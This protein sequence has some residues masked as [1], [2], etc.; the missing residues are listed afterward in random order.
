MP[1]VSM[2]NPPPG[3]SRKATRAPS[4]E[5]VTSRTAAATT[6]RVLSIGPFRI[7]GSDLFVR[8]VASGKVGGETGL[9][10]V[11]LG[12][13]DPHESRQPVVNRSLSV[14]KQVFAIGRSRSESL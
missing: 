4:S 8:L 2:P 9:G 13:D 14:A 11:P 12:I 10:A 5:T 3:G 7:Q 1:Y 6:L